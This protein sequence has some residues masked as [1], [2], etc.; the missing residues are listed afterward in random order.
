[1]AKYLQTLDDKIFEILK[2]DGEKKGL[3]IQEITRSAIVDYLKKEGL[4]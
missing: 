2:K 4:I 3:T 1:M